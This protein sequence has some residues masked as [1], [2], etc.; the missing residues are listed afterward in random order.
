MSRYE[1]E[2]QTA[3][4][5]NFVCCPYCDENFDGEVKNWDFID[6]E[7]HIVKCKKCKR[8]YKIMISRPIEY[9]YGRKED[10]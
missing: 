6:E 4:D 1:Y 5:I 9:V 8:Q 10:F 3:T 2:L 7:S